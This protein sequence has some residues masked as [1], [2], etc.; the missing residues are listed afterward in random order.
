MVA[1]MYS[2]TAFTAVQTILTWTAQSDIWVC[3]AVSIQI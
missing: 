3:H 1:G 2:V